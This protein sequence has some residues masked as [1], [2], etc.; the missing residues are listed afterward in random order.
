MSLVASITLASPNQDDRPNQDNRPNGGVIDMIV[1]HYTGMPTARAALDRLRDPAA[2][3]S[4]HYLVDEDGTVWSLVPEARRAWHA[5]VSHWRG[6]DG[7]N[8]RSIGIEIVNPGHEWGYRDF[9]ALQTAV[10]CDLCLDILSRHNVP[11]R[12]I[13]AHSDIAPDR[14]QDPGELFDWEGLARNGV[15]LWPDPMPDA[16][17]PDAVVPDL[18]LVRAALRTIGYQ[19]AAEGGMDAPLASV[20]RAFQRHWRPEAITG[21]ADAATL[22]RLLSVSRLVPGN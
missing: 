7:L 9:P 1:L 8:D 15:G 19:L 10:V 13:V 20:L 5:G 2:K 11:A 4:S 12:N 14:K 17:R 3:V 22:A 6:H 16:V 21:T 18:A